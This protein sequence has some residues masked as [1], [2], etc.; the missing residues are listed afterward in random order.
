MK[1]ANGSIETEVCVVGGGPGGLVLANLLGERGVGVTVL[2]RNKVYATDREFRGNSLT[3]GC[4]DALVKAGML[5]EA[6]LSNF[7]SVNHI[8]MYDEGKLIFDI[9]FCDGSYSADYGWKDIPQEFFL[10]QLAERLNTLPSVTFIPSARFESVITVNGKVSGVNAHV[11][12]SPVTVKSRLVVGADGR[13]SK[14]RK[15]ANFRFVQRD[16]QRDALWFKLKT[17][18][19]W[20]G[21]A[22]V[23]ISADEHL[24]ILPTYPHVL[25]IAFR[26]PKGGYKQLRDKGLE[27][28]YQTVGRLEP[29]LS[30]SVRQEVKGW[31]DTSLLDI[32]KVDVD[33][34]AQEGVV[35][36]GDAAQTLSPV[37]G[38]GVNVAIQDA[39]CIAPA[40]CAGLK[41]GKG[42]V[43]S[44]GAFKKYEQ[45]RKLVK[46]FIRRVQDNQE[47][48]LSLKS[49]PMVLFR[50]NMMRIR[51]KMSGRKRELAGR[52]FFNEY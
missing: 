33:S 30:D 52:L 9:N 36:I 12:G 31:G 23:T 43:L 5:T 27:F 35:L 50:R 51:N 3:A 49:A 13:Y 41:D 39:F 38:Q 22:K 2:E 40:I 32:I 37:L 6:D 29:R 42:K 21:L 14:V 47:F 46:S 24:A 19:G 48:V 25:R 34:W 15:A 17:P 7:T 20:G 16:Y 10:N 45:Q 8:S 44:A 1:S 26:V 28:F 18:A 4:T 11:G